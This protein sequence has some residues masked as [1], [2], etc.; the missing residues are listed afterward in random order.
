MPD[1]P[2]AFVAAIDASTWQDGPGAVGP[3]GLLLQ[4]V[5]PWLSRVMSPTGEP[6]RREFS[7][8]WSTERTVGVC[9]SGHPAI[10]GRTACV[11]DC[12]A[13][14]VKARMPICLLVSATVTL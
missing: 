12:V 8:M 2:F 10:S 14:S 1:P 4:G 7:G 13:L 5:E 11:M 3:E 9:E 6:H